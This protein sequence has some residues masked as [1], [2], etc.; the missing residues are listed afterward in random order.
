L[1]IFERKHRN[2]SMLADFCARTIRARSCAAD[3]C[4]NEPMCHHR[5]MRK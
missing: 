2:D 1:L 3:S 5:V 4:I